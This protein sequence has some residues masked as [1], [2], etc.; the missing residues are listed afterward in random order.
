MT[1]I[2]ITQIAS[3]SFNNAPS[4]DDSEDTFTS[5]EQWS[6]S[7][8]DDGT[9]NNTSDECLMFN[10][11]SYDYNYSAA[12]Q[13]SFNI[14]ADL[15]NYCADAIMY[16]ST[17]MLNDTQ[18]VNVS[19]DNVNWR[20]IM[21]SN[22]SYP[23]VWEVTR[24]S[25]VVEGTIVTFEIH[26][27]ID[28]CFEN[29]TE[30]QNYSYNLAI[31]FGLVDLNT[32]YKLD[33]VSDDY[34]LSEMSF[35]LSA[36]LNNTCAGDIHYPSGVL[37][38]G[39]GTTSSPAEG[40]Q[41]T[42]AMAYM[43][44]ENISTTVN[45]QISINQNISNGT[46]VNYSLQP[47]CSMY[48]FPISAGLYPSYM[49]DCSDSTLDMV[50]YSVMIGVASNQTGNQTGDPTDNQTDEP[51]NYSGTCP[52]SHPYPS[53]PAGP[54]DNSSST[55]W[56]CVDPYVEEYNECYP[57]YDEVPC[58][59]GGPC[60]QYE[61]PVMVPCEFGT[62]QYEA[63]A[64]VIFYL[65][66][67]DSDH[68]QHCGTIQFDLHDEAA[69]LHS[70]NFRDH[71]D[72]GNYDGTIFHRI[73][74]DFMIQGGDF[75]NSIG[76][77]GYAYSWHGYCNGNQ[78]QQGDCPTNQFTLPDETNTTFNHIPGALSMA[79]TSSP[80]T[81]G[82]QFF[83]VDAGVTPVHLDGV[84]TV[85]GQAVAGSIDGQSVSGLE[86]VDAISRVEVSGPYSSQPN[87]DVMII[88]AESFEEVPC[89]SG[90]PC[91]DTEET[92]EEAC[93][94]W[95]YWNPD[96]VDTTL[97]GNGC[98]HYIDESST[99]DSWEE[100]CEVWEYWNPDLVDTTLPGNGCPEYIDESSTE[101]DDESSTEDEETE[102]LLPGFSSIIAI[103]ALFGAALV[104]I[105]KE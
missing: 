72:A 77:G 101:D 73:I 23:V 67:F 22:S 45:W 87:H 53:D 31:P 15:F 49:Q 93:E 104:R 33:N 68:V 38:D 54:G 7:G 85:F 30:S 32:C 89:L 25:T 96:L 74:D 37:Y 57:T 48:N 24:D 83:I 56:C 36:S 79:K 98:P 46:L 91:D 71:V 16:P 20:Y 28:N 70:Q 39:D 78:G 2:L 18:G 50:N 52:E 60:D 21:G 63:Y 26:P 40:T 95:E 4:S 14:T 90:E 94:I 34:I 100:A 75:E 65:S 51:V 62:I 76:T 82:S 11:V 103:S 3:L 5:D 86:V 8:R 6:V 58:P 1:I 99:E 29:C 92:W 35:N 9:V 17:L 19:S 55:N 64:S 44:Y 12:P 10:N 84:H 102:G 81:G 41:N 59:S 66:W 42:G 47:V 61:P 27:T 88:S 97:P 13:D 105:R 80:N 69:P 43:I